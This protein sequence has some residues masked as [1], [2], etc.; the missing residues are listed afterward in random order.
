MRTRGEGTVY[1]RPN[2]TWT[3]QVT[4]PAGRRARTF[5][6]QRKAREWLTRQRRDMDTGEY[7]EP[8]D[9]PLGEWWDKWVKAYKTGL[10]VPST[11]DSYRYS[12]RRLSQTLLDAPIGRITRADIQTALNRLVASRRT[13]EIT[14]TALRMCMESAVDA[15][16]A[17]INPV[18]DIALPAPGSHKA[19]A[20]LPADEEALVELLT[21]PPATKSPIEVGS[22]AVRDSLLLILRTGLRR[23]ECVRLTWADIR[24]NTVHVRGTKTAASTRTIPVAA[25]D[26]R[27]MLARRREMGY[28]FAFAGPSGRPVCGSSLLRWMETHT[29]YTVHD[30]RH[31]YATRARQAG[32]D[33]ETLQRLL[34]H[35]RVETTLGIYRHVTDEEIEVAAAKIAANCNRSA[36]D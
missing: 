3:A 16:L 31:T 17:R 10:V 22:Q 7:V 24:G 1:Q 26:A 27:A 6:T 28:L 32:V 35:A 8:S 12:K 20:L 9:M 36:T 13:V 33:V 2:G 14:R 18:R 23:S 25:E 30:L 11:L 34:G 5:P 19:R 29:D 4:T 21:K 15:G